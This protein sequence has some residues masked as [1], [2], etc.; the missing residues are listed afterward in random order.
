MAYSLAHANE[1]LNFFKN[2]VSKK[3]HFKFSVGSNYFFE[4]SKLKAFRILWKSLLENYSYKNTEAHIFSTPTLRNKTIYDYNVNMLRTTS[5]CMSAVLG[6]SNTISNISYDQVYHKANEFGERISRNQL[7]ILKEESYFDSENDITKGSYYIENIT[8]QLAE[9]ALQIFKQIE[10]SGGFLNQLKSGN[11][12]KKIAESANI[13]QEKF[14]KKE[15]VLLGTNVFEK[16]DE[17][18]NSNLELYPFLKQKNH[19]T[20]LIP[21]LSKRLA[22][23]IEKQRLKSEK[24]HG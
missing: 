3:F 5:E 17:K 7:L 14:D 16:E 20:L 6:S 8:H 21:I 9:K 11:I 12:Q 13:E 19:K 15:I 23:N 24:S 4:I 18:M 2:D 10:K 22:E 1:F